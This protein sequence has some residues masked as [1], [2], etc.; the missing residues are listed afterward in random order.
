[1]EPHEYALNLTGDL[2]SRGKSFIS[3][4]IIITLYSG[5]PTITSKRDSMIPICIIYSLIHRAYYTM[6]P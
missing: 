1:M 3:D 4:K 5:I 2:L 6:Y